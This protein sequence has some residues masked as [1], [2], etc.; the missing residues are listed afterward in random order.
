MEPIFYTVEDL[1]LVLYPIII[2]E[3]TLDIEIDTS[4]NWYIQ[5]V[6]ITT[7]GN[8]V[9]QLAKGDW[10]EKEIIASVYA[11]RDLCNDIIK[12]CRGEND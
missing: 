1:E 8:K 11:D 9:V 10:I 7:T 5:G 6:S 3:C 4:R 12:T 2:N